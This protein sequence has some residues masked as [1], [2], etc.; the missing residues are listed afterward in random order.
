M[1]LFFLLSFSII[2][3]NDTINKIVNVNIG[4]V[5]HFLSFNKKIV[6]RGLKESPSIN[7]NNSL[8]RAI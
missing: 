4:I 7:R 5:H 3:I 1:N 6:V 8:Y 2:S